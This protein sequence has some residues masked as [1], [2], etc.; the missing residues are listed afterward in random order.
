MNYIVFDLEWNQS[1]T[2]QEDT[3][4]RFPF[5]I[6][7]I[8]AV[9]MEGNGHIGEEFSELVKPQ[10]YRVM[11]HV[12]GKLV[13][14][15]MAQLQQGRKFQEVAAEFEKWCGD[16]EFLY[17]T[18]GTLDLMELQRNRKFYKMTPLS[19]V[20]M[21]YLD[22]QKLFALTF[23]Q[24]EP[25]KRRSLEDAVDYLQ[26]EKEIPFH[27]ACSDAW[28]TARVLQVILEKNPEVTEQ[29]SYDTFYPPR[30]RKQEVKHQF[31][32]YFKFISR[33]YTDRKALLSDREVCSSRCYLC[34]RNLRKKVKWFTTNNRHFYCLAYCET[35]GWLKGK[36][37]INRTQEGEF[38]AVKTTRLVTE[39]VAQSVI[40][41]WE[42]QKE[43]KKK[44]QQKSSA[45]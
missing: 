22:V 10:V 9:R 44:Q 27:R 25:K 23:D 11:H 7:E 29:V 28:Y 34:R 26:I 35:H 32:T 40:D 8:G 42:H 15:K 33:V 12:T 1:N 30:D 3:V 20:P 43:A 38:Y 4:E 31:K 18:W 5:E 16:E 36:I 41:R 17:C 14:L 24:E 6:I 2:G 13:H 39:D 21:Q 45:Q 37:R 19:E